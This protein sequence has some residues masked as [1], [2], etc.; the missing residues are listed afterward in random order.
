M[1][2]GQDG[3]TPEGANFLWSFAIWGIE[4]SFVIQILR[5]V[6]ELC[7][8]AAR[9]FLHV[10]SSDKTEVRLI[11]PSKFPLPPSGF[12]SKVQTAWNLLSSC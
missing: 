2:F 4:I 12:Y 10:Y 5:F 3:I 6:G 8:G 7:G 9:I 11:S 1:S